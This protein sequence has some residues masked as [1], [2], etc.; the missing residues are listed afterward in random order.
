MRRAF[1]FAAVLFAGP[2]AVAALPADSA[3]NAVA[4]AERAMYAGDFTAAQAALRQA[5]NENP[6]P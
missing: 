1:L 4:R 2:F 6:A 3:S 5:L